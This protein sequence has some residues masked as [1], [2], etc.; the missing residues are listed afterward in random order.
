[1]SSFVRQ[2]GD[3][4]DDDEFTQKINCTIKYNKILPTHITSHLTL[5]NNK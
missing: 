4:E 2:R 3:D 1:M 5:K